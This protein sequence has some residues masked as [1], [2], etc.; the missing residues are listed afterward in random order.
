[1]HN[2]RFRKS[3]IAAGVFVLFSVAAY[4]SFNELSALFGGPQAQYKHAIAAIVMLL[5][6]KWPI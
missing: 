1:M 3:F 5:V 4:W 2:S 6:L